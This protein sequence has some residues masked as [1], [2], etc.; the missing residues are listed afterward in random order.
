MKPRVFE[1]RLEFLSM[2]TV[3]GVWCIGIGVA[4]FAPIDILEKVPA[5][6]IYVEQMLGLISSGS[7][8][9]SRSNFPQV[10]QLYY[11]LLAWTIPFFVII[12]HSWMMTRVAKDRDGLLFRRKLS[13]ANK[14]WFILL[15]PIWIAFIYFASLNHGGDTRL[16]PFGGSRWALGIFGIAFPLGV[17]AMIA[18]ISFSVRRVF[19][20]NGGNCE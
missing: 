5:L 1:S 6:K 8:L 4:A 7:R 13:I 3:L 10:T 15:I 19:F 2:Y 18:V 11:A 16:I 17:G 12:S 9:G 20:E 14:V